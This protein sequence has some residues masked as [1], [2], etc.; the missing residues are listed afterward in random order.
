MSVIDEIVNNLDIVDYISRY[1]R[2]KKSGNS[3][4]GL[5]PLHNG[6]NSNS[7][8]VFPDTNT[9]YC[10]S[11]GKGGSLVDFVREQIKIPIIEALK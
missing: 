11:C 1:T 10:F 5:C 7:L 3:Y 6:D 8:A 2:L 9:F 4:R